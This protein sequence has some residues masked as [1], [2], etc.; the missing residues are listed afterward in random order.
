M[1]VCVC[2]CVCVCARARACVPECERI[3]EH[4]RA[5]A[6]SATHGLA[7]LFAM[8][9]KKYGPAMCCLMPPVSVNHIKYTKIGFD[10]KS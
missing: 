8:Q 10:S 9:K 3:C 1:C 2:V 5:R 6:L 4:A 7:S